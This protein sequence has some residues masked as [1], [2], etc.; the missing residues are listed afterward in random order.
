MVDAF[1]FPSYSRHAQLERDLAICLAKDVFDKLE[2]WIFTLPWAPPDTSH[3]ALGASRH[4]IDDR[5]DTVGSGIRRL[6]LYVPSQQ[7]SNLVEP[8][9]PVILLDSVQA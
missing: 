4:V 9:T 5:Q 6:T 1:A 7:D 2:R 8:K 3:A